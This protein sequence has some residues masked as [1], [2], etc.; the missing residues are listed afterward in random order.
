M[1]AACAGKF[2][3]WGWLDVVRGWFRPK[4]ERHVQVSKAL[5]LDGSTRR[6]VATEV[7]VAGTVLSHVEKKVN[8]VGENFTGVVL[9]LLFEE[10]D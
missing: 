9:D 3:L 6:E 5:R 10:D 4:R 7:K 8:V 1:S 2:W